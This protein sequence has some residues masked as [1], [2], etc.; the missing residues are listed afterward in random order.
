MFRDLTERERVIVFLALRELARLS[1]ERAE[2]LGESYP[3]IAQD[4][5]ADAAQ[6]LALLAKAS[7]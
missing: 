7:A 5:R 4:E 6:A 2:A 1:I 3:R